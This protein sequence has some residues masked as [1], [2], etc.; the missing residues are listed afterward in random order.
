MSDELVLEWI[1]KAEEDWTAIE[2]LRAG[3]LGEVADPVVFHAQQTAEKYLKALAQR[4]GIEPPR[5][6]HLPVLLDLL[7]GELPELEGLRAPCE[8]LAPFAVSFRYPGEQA[9]EEDARHAVALSATIRTALRHAL[10]L[11]PPPG[12]AADA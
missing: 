6:H 3:D 5:T 12:N 11:E 10:G 9:T 7:V 8:E 2:R 4:H 1:A